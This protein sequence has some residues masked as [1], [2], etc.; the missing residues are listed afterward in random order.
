MSSGSS[1]GLMRFSVFLRLNK[2]PALKTENVHS[3]TTRY[4]QCSVPSLLTGPTR[5]LCSSSQGDSLH[6]L[7]ALHGSYKF[8]C[9]IFE[10]KIKIRME[11]GGRESAIDGF[12]CSE[13]I[14]HCSPQLSPDWTDIS[15]LQCVEYFNKM[16]RQYR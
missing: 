15:Q 1:E 7:P 6:V 10:M 8:S 16:L 3:C 2:H 5:R 11:E 14:F 12:N 9:V 13:E 4:P